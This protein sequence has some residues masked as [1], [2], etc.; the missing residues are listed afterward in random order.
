MYVH[1]RMHELKNAANVARVCARH[2]FLLIIIKILCCL[3]S[4]RQ[5]LF[6]RSNDKTIAFKRLVLVGAATLFIRAHS[7]RRDLFRR[8]GKCLAQGEVHGAHEV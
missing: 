6:S 4:L 7:L 8:R 3:N 1:R 5:T 2:N